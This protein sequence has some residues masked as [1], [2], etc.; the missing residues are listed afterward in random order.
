MQSI[1]DDLLPLAIEKINAKTEIKDG[2]KVKGIYESYLSQFG[3]MA[4]QIGIRSTLAV[5]YNKDAESSGGDRK[6]ILQLIFD[7]LKSN[8]TLNF[9]NIQ[10][11]NNWIEAILTNTTDIDDNIESLLLDASVALKRAIRTFYLKDKK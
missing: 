6:H 9:A 3:P 10:N 2:V 8:T 11:F 7:V 4:Y 5:Y 1:I